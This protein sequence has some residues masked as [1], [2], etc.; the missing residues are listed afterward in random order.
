MDDAD[1]LQALAAVAGD[2]GDLADPAHP[3]LVVRLAG[4]E[5]REL[6]GAHDPREPPVRHRH[7]PAEAL[8]AVLVLG[9]ADVV[10]LI[11]L[12]TDA[13]VRGH[14]QPGPG[15]LDAGVPRALGA[16]DRPVLDR[17]RVLAEVPDVPAQVL[18]VVVLRGL[19]DA[20]V[21]VAA[22][23]DDDAAD[24]VDDLRLARHL[25]DVAHPGA[26]V[27]AFGDERRAGLQ[28][29]PLVVDAGRELR[30][31]RLGLA[32]RLAARLV[33]A[34][35]GGEAEQ[36]DRGAPDHYVSWLAARN[37]L[38]TAAGLRLSMSTAAFIRRI[39]SVVNFALTA[40]SVSANSGPCWSSTFLET[41]GAT[42]WK[43][44][45]N[46]GSLSTT[47]LPRCS[48]PS[49][50]KT[51]AVSMRPLSSALYCRPMESGLK[52]KLLRPYSSLSPTRPE[53]RVRNSG[54][55][56]SAILPLTFLRS[57]TLLRPYFDA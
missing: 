35:G 26:P 6:A 32:G 51:S 16:L 47:Y 49:V 22:V 8:D 31:R 37:A 55:A 23:V 17:R 43:P 39:A 29:H 50:V 25:E 41:T 1:E 42:F 15:A 18:D 48:W 10:L 14:E 30:R 24:A 13:R 54:G 7:P 34:P 19:D 3:V 21:L 12:L 40:L 33:A 2:L 57:A 20:A 27:D 4:L 46:F 36:Q 28:R 5:P 9:V 52:S 45:M 53:K 56:P 38:A 11:V 44:K